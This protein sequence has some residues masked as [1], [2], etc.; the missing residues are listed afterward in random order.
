MSKISKPYE[1]DE[2]FKR[3]LVGLA[4][5]TKRNYTQEFA[6]W[7][8]FIKMTPTEQIQKRMQDLTTTNLNERQFFENKFREYKERLEKRGTL[9][10][11]AVRTKLNVV[12]SFF[13]RNGLTLNL[14]RGDWE[15]TQPQQ[16]IIKFKLTKED[17]KQLY[18]HGNLRDRALLLVLGHSGLSEVDVSNLHV[19]DFPELYSVDEGQHLFFEKPREKTGEIQATC[20]SYE[21]IHDIRAM[22]Q[23]RGNPANGYLFVS[24]TK[25][26]GKQLEV[27]SISEAMKDLAVKTFG[28]EK[29]KDFQTKALR[30]FY[31]SVLLHASIQPQEL[32]DL[33]FGH[34]RKGARGHYDFDE[35]TIKQN[36]AKAFEFMSINGLQTR[37]DIAK[38][39][40]EFKSTKS[41]LA[42]LI[43]EQQR[44]LAQQKQE[45]GK[46]Q[47]DYESVKKT[48]DLFVK[49]VNLI[50]VVES[51][52][53]AKQLLDFLEKMRYNKYIKEKIEQSKNNGS[54]IGK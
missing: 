49:W 8:D 10:H 14:K 30:S 4:D 12:A 26:K 48:L 40:E 50:D 18:A 37:T 27:R 31:N 5:R 42:E 43:A 28:K 2:F 44:E 1:E 21:A 35:E 16:V 46:T 34:A 23:E 3:W 25:E 7:I 33:M 41:E 29:A 53:D 19:E 15:S 51:E 54:N 32:K 6:D 17:V 20:L 45:L 36:Y 9:Q 13:S 39:K 22:L 11:L 47:N 52:T 38:L 24:T